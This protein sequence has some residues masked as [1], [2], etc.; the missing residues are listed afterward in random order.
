MTSPAPPPAPSMTAAPVPPAAPAVTTTQ[1]PMPARPAPAPPPRRVAL[2]DRVS[3][4]EDKLT[5][6]AA[7]HNKFADDVSRELGL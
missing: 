7:L 4:L 3:S 5:Q 2:I 1:G 6:L